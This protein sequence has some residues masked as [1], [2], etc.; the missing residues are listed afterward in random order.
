MNTSALEVFR[1]DCSLAGHHQMVAKFQ[2]E[3]FRG[4]FS[5]RVFPFWLPLLNRCCAISSNGRWKHWNMKVVSLGPLGAS[6]MEGLAPNSFKKGWKPTEWPWIW[7]RVVAA[8]R[9]AE[10]TFW[11]VSLTC[12][13]QKA[14]DVFLSWVFLYLFGQVI[15]YQISVI[16]Q[17]QDFVWRFTITAAE[18]Q[19]HSRTSLP[20][21]SPG[22]FVNHISSSCG[23]CMTLRYQ[24]LGSKACALRRV[25]DHGIIYNKLHDKKQSNM[26]WNM[27]SA[28]TCMHCL[29]ASFCH[30]VMSDSWWYW[31]CLKWVEHSNLIQILNCTWNK[32]G[33]KAL[34]IYIHLYINTYIYIN[35]K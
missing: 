33:V 13:F 15:F 22:C 25:I 14:T 12:H 17:E 6:K 18:F 29:F 2:Q 9:T 34:Y 19:S 31:T 8:E 26:G 35:A 30:A 23:D 1:S 10:T 32:W 4:R 24:G 3:I 20:K 11:S 7:W 27:L 16:T 21:S 5:S 28:M